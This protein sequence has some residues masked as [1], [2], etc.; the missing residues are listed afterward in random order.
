MPETTSQAQL[1][2]LETRSQ[3]ASLLGPELSRLS[4]LDP[5]QRVG[6][7]LVFTGLLA[8][9]WSCPW[10]PL[11]FLCTVVALNAFVLLMHE[12]MHGLLFRDRR[13]N[14]WVSVLISSFLLLSFSAYTVMHE[15][16]HRYLGDHRDPD[17]YDNYVKTPVLVWAMQ[18]W[19]LTLGSFF[20]LVLIPILS[21]RYG[22]PRARRFVIQEY[23]LMGAAYAVVWHC[24]DH[25]WLL[26]QWFL[27]LVCVGL[28]TNLRGL[29]QHGV[30]D[31]HDPLLASR[32]VHI[33]PFLAYLLLN[34]NFHL[35][36]H[37]FPEVPSYNLPELHRRIFPSL[38]R[39]VVN[40]GYGE[41]LWSFLKATPTLDRTPIGLIRRGDSACD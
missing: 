26:H 35:E 21:L 32:S 19:R 39:A 15:R 9:S 33:H 8:Y 34:E 17:D 13:L 22:S 18:Y 10:R 38:P 30:A 36:H 20:Y 27:P 3:L 6:G 41:F 23:L 14:R 5:A 11:G 4:Q 12:G 7:M 2:H 31:A 40:R 28:F 24:V 16:H 1:R 37:L 25:N 29:T